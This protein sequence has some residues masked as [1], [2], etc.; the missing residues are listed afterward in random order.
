MGQTVIRD[1][2]VVSLDPDIG[3]VEGADVLIEDGEIVSVGDDLSDVGGE[4]L[5]ASNAIVMPGFV[6]PHL[7]AYQ[8]LFRGIGGDWP[9][10]DYV[11]KVH[12]TIDGQYRP[13]DT[14][15]GNLFSATEHL[16]AGIST[17]FD[18]CHN[19]PT[20][21]HADRAIDGL[22]DAGIRAVFAHGPP[23][24]AEYREE[25]H[26]NSSRTHP[27]YIRDLR[28]GRLADDDARVT[29]GMAARGPDFTTREVA[30]H[31][32]QLAKDLGIPVSMH[33]GVSSYEAYNREGL[34]ELVDDDLLHEHS[35]ITHGNDLHEDVLT[36]L[37]SVDVP[38]IT[39]PEAELQVGH[40]FPGTRGFIDAGI[41]V[42]VG[43][44]VIS[45]NSGE[46]FTP[47]RLALQVQRGFDNKR[48]QEEQGSVERLS[49]TTRDALEWTTINAARS[50]G[51]GDT[52]G[53][54]T[55]G[56]RA[57]VTVISTDDINTMPGHSPVDTIVLQSNPSN[58]DTVL[59][60]G[61][62]VKRDG[63]LVDP[64]T[65][66]LEEEFYAA[67]ERLVDGAGI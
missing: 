2:T 17:V 39:T 33:A 61:E 48:Q 41:E 59:V 36:S 42:S 46:Q 6:D 1:G 30:R 34:L 50:I 7:H 37:A 47:M 15:L 57:D 53:S 52:V 55:P 24:G 3:V 58:V 26:N 43:I 11:A 19:I 18:F 4:E 44:D 64:A 9:M 5:D 56:K 23:N 28:E 14:Y 16:N 67:S 49:L 10:A 8:A 66:G 35:S 31:D 63:A 40:G 54:L 12:G 20:S 13:R 25:W 45:I 38:L 27:D 21:E 65:A 32:L 51:L 29:L 60:D 22:E 62:V